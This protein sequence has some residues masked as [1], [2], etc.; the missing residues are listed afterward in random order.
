[1]WMAALLA[2]AGVTPA[3][4]VVE[5]VGWVAMEEA[6]NL[7]EGRV[8]QDG[9]PAYLRVGESE[10]GGGTFTVLRFGHP[11]I[12]APSYALTGQVRYQ[13]VAGEGYLEMWNHFP[14]DQAF[15]SR[16]LSP[17]GPL[18][19]LSGSSAWRP[20]LLPFTKGDTEGPEKLVVN[21]VL[22]EGGQVDL[23]DL[24][25]LQ[26]PG[27]RAPALLGGPRDGWWGDRTGGRIGAVAGLSLGLL[28]PAIAF[29]L[30]AGWAPRATR[31]VTLLL[32][33]AGDA[34]LV[35]GLVA[36]STGQPYAVYYPLLLVGFLTALLSIVMLFRGR[37]LQALREVQRLEA[38]NVG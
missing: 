10:E 38:M 6:G 36:L 21:V 9:G 15:F 29:L 18:Q 16:T 35:I 20:F 31:A 11:G 32:Q 34:C 17:S 4:E 1:M 27:G 3:A 12:S 2:V 26:Y 30:H 5:T 19:A 25:L 7:I 37:R 33:L 14:G 24:R 8:V 22:P 23:R 28:F 13:G